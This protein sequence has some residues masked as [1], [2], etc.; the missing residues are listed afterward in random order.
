MWESSIM[1][2]DLYYHFFTYGKKSIRNLC[3]PVDFL[4]QEETYTAVRLYLIPYDHAFAH[5]LD[6]FLISHRSTIK[7][8]PAAL[9]AFLPKTFLLIIYLIGNV[10]N[11][12]AT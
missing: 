5:S 6:N 3:K 12:M 1:N 8:F 9:N 10:H 4:P 2:V 7:M 11:S